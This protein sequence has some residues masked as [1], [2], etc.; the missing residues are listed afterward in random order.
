MARTLDDLIK[1]AFSNVEA[2]H[3]VIAN[4]N[5]APKGLDI[6]GRLGKALNLLKTASNILDRDKS[7]DV[8]ILESDEECKW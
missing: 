7:L 2:V 4:T 1:E 6:L 5:E 3:W 8:D